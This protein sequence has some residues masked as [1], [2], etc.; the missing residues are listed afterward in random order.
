MLL[1]L[2]QT[3]PQ[4]VE[5][6][7]FRWFYQPFSISIRYLTRNI[8][9]SVGDIIY[10]IFGFWIAY[11]VF[12]KFLLL[13]NNRIQK[14]LIFDGLLI[15]FLIFCCKIY[16]IFKLFWGLNYARLGVAYQFNL[17]KEDYCK[18]Q[19]NTYIDEL[20]TD[21]NLTRSQIA[22]TALPK[23]SISNSFNLA[24]EAYSQVSKSYSFLDYK[25]PSIKKSLFSKLGDYT[26]F[27]G[28]FNPFSGESQVRSDIPEIL[29]PFIA[30]HEIAHQL[31]YAS[32]SEASFI[33]YIICSNSNNIYFKYS[34]QLELLA[35]A[36]NELP[37]KY[38]EDGCAE[39]IKPRFFQIYDCISKQVK[40]DRK[41]II[42][43]FDRNRSST[44]AV[45][46]VIYDNYLKINKQY[47][48]LRSYNEVLGWVLSQKFNKK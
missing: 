6:V 37:S 12:N 10:I 47:T 38:L 32:E 26:G 44:V 16:I 19:L 43:F 35:L 34:I 39:E 46:N 7:Y 3:K 45:S 18:E 24:I 23:I 48:G 31:G 14:K 30:S 9:F 33:G 13:K 27:V 36:L 8:P 11:K 15:P 28:Y 40:K 1:W 42:D 21:I 41:T 4:F 5:D 22:D 29:I 25:N 2:F 17:Q 20:I